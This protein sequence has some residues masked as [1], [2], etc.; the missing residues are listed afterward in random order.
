M[1]P[2]EAAAKVKLATTR[3]EDLAEQLEAA[4]RD[5][6]DAYADAAREG[7]GPEELAAAPRSPPTRS[8]A[9]CG[10]AA[11]GPPSGPGG[12]R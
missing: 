7:L 3:Y 9:G 5:L 6:L 12:G 10:S 4:K 1:G 8:P 11:R 2:E